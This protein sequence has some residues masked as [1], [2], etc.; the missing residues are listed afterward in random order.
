MRSVNEILDDLE[1]RTKYGA[2]NFYN[3]LED[4]NERELIH[5][6]YKGKLTIPI[7]GGDIKLQNAAGTLIS[8]GYDRV[9]IGDY[10]AYIEF[11][12]DQA[13]TENFELKYPGTPKRPVKYLWLHT[14]DNLKTKIYL[15]KAK[16]SYADYKPGF[17]YIAT[18]DVDLGE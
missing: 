15:Q 14:K 11:N 9:V 3:K 6:Y 12:N 5:E 8:E 7:N 18:S 16:V 10:G 13:I 17:Y 1:S 2:K 4:K